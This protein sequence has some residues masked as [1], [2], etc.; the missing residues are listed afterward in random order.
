MKVDVV[1]TWVDGGNP[2]YWEVV[3]QYA[4]AKKDMNPERFRDEYQMLRYSMRSLHQ[5]AGDWIGK[6]YVLTAR[7]QCPP[8]LNVDHP[9]VILKHHDEFFR[10]P[11]VLPTFSC[12]NIEPEM[13]NLPC[14][15]PFL[16]F[17]DDYLLG[18]PATPELFRDKRG[19]IRVFGTLIGERFR[20]RIRQ[21]GISLGFTEHTPIWIDKTAY[22]ATNRMFEELYQATLHSRF[23]QDWNY[24][25]ER[26]YRYYLLAHTKKRKA[27]PFWTALRE[28][29]FH[30]ITNEELK[31]QKQLARIE[32]RRP[33]FICLNDDQ[34]DQP[35]PRVIELVQNFLDRY[36][37][38]PSPWEKI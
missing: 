31:Q 38:K 10:D 6:V 17:N 8:W 29:A 34:G 18:A 27:V 32:K 4:T 5:F 3:R 26:A 13:H 33:P 12:L 19:N 24:R 7:P 20:S 30:K 21:G 23:R 14:S 35:N 36:Y 25:I 22:E 37:P 15:D 28:V 2:E 9:D 1:Y 16:Y 11:S